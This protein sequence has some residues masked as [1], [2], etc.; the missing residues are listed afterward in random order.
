MG[1]GADGYVR[2]LNI[3]ARSIDSDEIIR[4]Q[5]DTP[6]L[7]Y[8]RSSQM[9]TITQVGM[10][11]SPLG[12]D[13]VEFHWTWDTQYEQQTT[14]SQG[15]IGDDLLDDTAPD[16][17]AFLLSDDTVTGDTG[18]LLGGVNFNEVYEDLTTGGEGRWIQYSFKQEVLAEDL[19]IHA[20]S[21]GMQ[22]D[23][24]SLE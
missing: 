8:G 22:F 24:S 9:K 1:G 19:F 7:N 16:A 12:N 15:D 17:E 23:A 11:L 18:S 14:I 21:V 3:D 4:A 13:T 20:F 6:H 2:Q 5:V 10:T